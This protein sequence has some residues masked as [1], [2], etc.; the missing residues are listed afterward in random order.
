MASII[1][2]DRSRGVQPW[3]RQ[4]SKRRM[5]SGARLFLPIGAV[6]TSV[7]PLSAQTVTVTNQSE[8]DA[9]IQQAITAGQ[10]NTIDVLSATPITADTGFVL[11][12]QASPLNLNFGLTPTLNV[13]VGTTGTLTFGDG[14]N[15]T[16]APTTGPAGWSVGRDAGGN[17]TVNM[18]GGVVSF[19]GSQANYLALNI[20]RGTGATGTFNQSG[21][22]V[23]LAGGALQIGVVGGTGTYNL[24]GNGSL[25]LSAT[26]G[27]LYLGASVGDVAL[28]HI[29]GDASF[30]GGRQMYVGNAGSLGIITQDGAGS[31]VVLNG[32]NFALFGARVGGGGGPAGTG[33][34]N[35]SAGNLDIGSSGASFGNASGGF[36]YF[37][38]S[39]GTFNT[40]GGSALLRI[41]QSGTGEYNLSGGTA[42]LAAGMDIGQFAGS[43]GT[44]NQSGGVLTLAGGVIHFLAGTGVYNLTG[45]TLQIGG[46]NPITTTGVGTYQFNLGGGTIQV[47]GSNLDSD[48]PFTLLPGTVSAIDTNGLSASL[49]GVLSGS[50][51]LAKT[52]AGS[53]ALSG[54]NTYSGGTFLNGGIL[55]VAADSDLG[56]TTGGL[57]F[58]GGTLQFLTGLMTNRTISL[59]AG[60]GIFDTNGNN[61]TLGGPIDGAGGLIKT[62]IGVLTL[63]GPGSYSGATTVDAGTL[64]TGAADVLSPVSAFSV[65]SL[66]ALNLN[67]F[68]QTI[69]SLSG[70]GAVALGSA[71]LTTGG[72]GSSTEFSGIVSGAGGLRKVGTGVFG[73]SGAN[74]YTGATTIDAGVLNVSG[75]LAS[76]VF[77]SNGGTLTGNGTVQNLAVG[78][79]GTVAPGNAT[80]NVSGNISFAAG[81][82]FEVDV[83]AAAPSSRLAVGGSATLA[84][85]TVQVFGTPARDLTYTILTAA[86][87]VTGTFANVVAPSSIF[88]STVLSYTP[89]SVLLS[90]QQTRAFVDV[91]V[92]PNQVSVAAALDALPA[93]N[94]LFESI[95]TQASAAGS[96]QAYDALSGELHASTQTVMLDDSRVVRQALLGRM[97]QAS[98]GDASG[99]MASLGGGPTVVYAQPALAFEDRFA[100]NADAF[101]SADPR[102]T[103]APARARPVAAHEHEIAWWTQGV[104]AWGKIASDQNAASIT[105]DLGGFVTGVDARFG[106]HWRAGLAGGYTNS[107][108]TVAS[109]ASSAVIETAHLAAYA[110]TNYGSWNLRSGVSISRSEV[111]T[112]RIIAFPGFF[113]RT[114]ARYGATTTQVFGEVGYGLL[115]GAIAAEPF[116]GLAGVHLST[117]GFN[118]A[119]GSA[120]LNGMHSSNDVGYSSIGARLASPFVLP[121]G[122]VLVPRAS[123][124]WQHAFG[125]V[126]PSAALAFRG[127]GAA[128]NISG[129]PLA[130]N[131]AL[132]EGGLDFVMTSQA[133]I[134]ISYVS[135]IAESAQDH[136]I[137][138]NLLVRF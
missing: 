134:G 39:G 37:N 79:G 26:A 102:G 48:T 60:S 38:Q 8:F 100:A 77:A 133:T 70:S 91:A 112:S 67:G 136:S 76:T 7:L 113:D 120:A 21:G 57:T 80:L 116:A 82:V 71:T 62:G 101:A 5:C 64:Q 93:G 81:S 105:R 107:N 126:A 87:G 16:F 97:R 124:A 10:P 44:V 59:G 3:S 27:T 25:A 18:T 28:L 68:D 137:K 135:Q 128:F 86:Q 35:L 15:L 130:Q 131:A 13:G 30:S 110:G 89:T 23:D 90:L 36:G 11:P 24:S 115:L 51:G 118:E 84:G 85:G 121:N 127:A 52:G 22:S 47:F 63:V 94:P 2:G 138:G 99:L 66:G 72:D 33:I 129:I 103:A 75:S 42:T 14:T 31:N 54:L 78:N 125:D 88:L 34:Y 9:A 20:G 17:G 56:A 98:F 73:L 32:L 55:Q 12:G 83:T 119:G 108:V 92:T 29:S 109:R 58:G 104:G 46:V 95:L 96:L 45:G 40:V 111:D 4:I 53:L 61:A 114:R 41:G 50:G 43:S 117:D 65:A 49:S 132:I 69:G 19:V 74:T 106:N 122:A 1:D 123:V 6:F